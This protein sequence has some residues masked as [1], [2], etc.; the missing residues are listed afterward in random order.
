MCNSIKKF[1]T[2]HLYGAWLDY[3]AA[4]VWEIS[5]DKTGPRSAAEIEPNM[6]VSFTLKFAC[7]ISLPFSKCLKV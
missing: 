4:A 7:L 6:E 2:G 3:Y 5:P 1:A